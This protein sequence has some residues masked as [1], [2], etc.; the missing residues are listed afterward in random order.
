MYGSWSKLYGELYGQAQSV[1]DK[2]NNMNMPLAFF[3]FGCLTSEA[4][5]NT[6]N[7]KSPLVNVR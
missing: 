7:C 5:F 1:A 2:T 4:N 3:I 6:C